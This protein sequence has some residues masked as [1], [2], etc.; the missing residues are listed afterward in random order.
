MPMLSPMVWALFG[1]DYAVP[2]ETP[3]EAME[4][5]REGNTVVLS[6]YTSAIRTL[7]MLGAD[8]DHATYLAQV[9]RRQ[10]QTPTQEVH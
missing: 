1:P 9:A 4:Q 7:V 5:V 10:P 6:D 2:C 3:R 8:V